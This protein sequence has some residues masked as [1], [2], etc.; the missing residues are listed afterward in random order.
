[1]HKTEHLHNDW[2]CFG[3][4]GHCSGFSPHCPTDVY[5]GQRWPAQRPRGLGRRQERGKL[6]AAIGPVRTVGICRHLHWLKAAV[7]T[8]PQPNAAVW[9]CKPGLLDLPIFFFQEKLQT[10]FFWNSYLSKN[11][12]R[13]KWHGNKGRELLQMKILRTHNQQI[14]FVNYAWIPI[15]TKWL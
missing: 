13:N 10:P 14:A 8:V 15:Q 7:P 4:Q 2:G 1:M 12:C 6:A 5:V 9:G 3:L 11:A